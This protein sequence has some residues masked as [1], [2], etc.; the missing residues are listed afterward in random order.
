MIPATLSSERRDHGSM[1]VLRKVGAV[2]EVHWKGFPA[3]CRPAQCYSSPV[4]MVIAI[5]KRAPELA[6]DAVR[7]WLWQ[8]VL[9]RHPMK[10]AGWIKERYFYGDGCRSWVFATKRR[11][12]GNI[13]RLRL[14]WAMT[15]PILRRVKIRSRANPF[16]PVWMSYFTRRQAATRRVELF[17][18]T[19]WC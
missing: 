16:D 10:G 9:R 5:E 8:W 2:A 11:V 17:G 13:H 14:F 7:Q 6:A 4:A 19:D 12:D 15:I 18:A 1:A 3:W